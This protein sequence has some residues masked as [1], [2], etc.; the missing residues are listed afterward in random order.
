MPEQSTLT[1]EGILKL[2]RETDRRME[3]TDRLMKETDMGA[4]AS[5][6]VV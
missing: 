1:Y 4:P 3:D 6:P 5:P 2:F